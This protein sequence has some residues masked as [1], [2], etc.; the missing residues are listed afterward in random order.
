MGCGPVAFAGVHH[1]A[2]LVGPGFVYFF[3]HGINFPSAQ[4]GSVAPFARHAGAAAGLFGFLMMA[5]AAIVGGWI[6]IS[7]N[8]TVYPLALTVTGCALISTAT[9]FGWISRLTPFA[10]RETPVSSA[11][12]GD[13]G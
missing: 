1:W 10:V 12:G 13:F 4:A 2:A 7:Y 11:T 9:A 8:G 3:A 5:F 6:G